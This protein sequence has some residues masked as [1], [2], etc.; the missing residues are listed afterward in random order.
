LADRQKEE[1]R[2]L[3][4]EEKLDKKL[5]E[6]LELERQYDAQL[7]ELTDEEKK[8]HREEKSFWKDVND[9]EMNLIDFEEERNKDHK[10]ICNIKEEVKKLSQTNVLNDIFKISMQS[11]YAIING[12][13]FGKLNV[14]TEKVGWDEIN[15]AIGQTVLLLCCLSKRF[16]YNF[17]QHDLHPLGNFSKI[18]NKNMKEK[19]KFELFMPSNENRFNY[20]LVQLLDCTRDM[21]DYVQKTFTFL[22]K[23]RV[24]Y[25]I[26]GETIGQYSIKYNSARLE[27][28]TKACKYFLTNIKWLVF[29]SAWKDMME[30]KSSNIRT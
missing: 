22:E 20:A 3:T 7:E 10:K 2:L 29:A 18:S 30:Q 11:E 25:A 13:R 1:E 15:A 9:F 26:T 27:D 6:M 23:N 12:L 16:N 17:K 5:E 8:L 14:A 4:E 28:W 24:P 19:E 21:C